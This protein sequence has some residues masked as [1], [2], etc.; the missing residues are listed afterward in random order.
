M[1]CQ[2]YVFSS[3]AGKAQSI[4]FLSRSQQQRMLPS[5][6]QINRIDHPDKWYHRVGT[7]KRMV[8]CSG[9][10]RRYRIVF[11]GGRTLV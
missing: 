8:H 6:N 1:T 9:N 3:S 2:L 10:L 7:A 5:E 11:D 4:L